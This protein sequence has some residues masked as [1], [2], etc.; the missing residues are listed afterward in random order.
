MDK[1]LSIPLEKLCHD[2]PDEFK[3]LFMYSRTLEF[4]QKP[5]YSYL[6]NLFKNMMEREHYEMD[7]NY[8]W[9][10]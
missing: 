10:R 1:K 3:Q 8:C 9:I 5:D 6:K 2:L 4:E 7:Y